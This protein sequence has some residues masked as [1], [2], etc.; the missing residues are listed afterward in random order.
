M[1]S[2]GM[3]K[4]GG[5]L[6]IVRVAIHAVLRA[7]ASRTGVRHITATGIVYTIPLRMVE[8]IESLGAELDHF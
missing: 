8:N 1:N 6:L 2:T 4:V 5:Y 7:G 3:Q